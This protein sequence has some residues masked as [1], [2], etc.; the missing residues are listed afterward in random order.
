VRFGSYRN[1]IEKISDEYVVDTTTGLWYGS[2]KVKYELSSAAIKYHTFEGSAST[3]TMGASLSGGAKFAG[4]VLGG[5]GKIYSVPSDS[6]DIL[7]IDPIAGTA[8]RSSMGATLS[9]TS[10]WYG[11]VLG[12]NG[13]IY[14]VPYGSTDILIIDPTAGT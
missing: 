14:C 3:V 13:K 7:I 8:S 2:V 5:N 11:G 1:S 4:C 12:G 9:G 10:K 6:T